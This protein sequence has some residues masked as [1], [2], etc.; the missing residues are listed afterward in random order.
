MKFEFNQKI[1][2]FLKIILK[3]AQSQNLRVFFVGG[4]VRDKI[5]DIPTF[6]IDLLLLGN[7]IE[8]SKSLPKEIKIKS[9]HQDFCTA[10]L[11]FDGVEIDIASSR[12]ESY[13]YSGCLPVLNEIGVELK[14]DVSRRDFGINSLY[15][16]LK[17]E[18]DEIFYTLIDMV[19][20]LKDIN[21]KVLK[22][23][24]DKSYIDDPT[25][26]IRGLGFKYRFNFDFSAHDKKLINEYLS[27]IDYSNMSLDRNTKVIKKVLNSKFQKEI[28][29]EIIEKKYYKILNSEDLD[30]DFVL[31]S[32]IFDN[33]C[34]DMVLMSKFYI[35]IIKNN[36]VKKVNCKNLLEI[37]KTFSKFS[38]LDLVYYFYKTKDENAVK[39][40]K[41]KD[42]SLFI[43]GQDL[44]NMGFKQGKIF[45][46]ILDSLMSQKLENPSEF[47]D[48][49]NELE[50]VRKKFLKV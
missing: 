5:L 7:A 29:R 13:P 11:E 12:S 28:F 40:F 35:E 14:K 22:V 34:L 25:R 15:C 27:K 50:W 4:I 3:N 1:N 20:G 38:L 42:I 10:K 31:I 44:I 8:F 32:K 33:F 17:L 45:S 49:K 39:Y 2:N 23:L 24:H 30:I 43:N 46:E 48:R 37:Y 21:D 19:D 36:D 9:I 26:I 16:E 18:N 47:K 41:I 6:D